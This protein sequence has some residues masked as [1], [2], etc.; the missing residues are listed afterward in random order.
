MVYKSSSA[1]SFLSIFCHSTHF[2][3]LESNDGPVTT[4]TETLA[5]PTAAEVHEFAGRAHENGALLTVFGRC[6]VEYVGAAESHLSTGDRHVMV[7][8]DGTVLVHTDE[9]QRPVNWQA[10]GGSLRFA[11]DEGFRVVGERGDTRLV[12]DFEMVQRASSFA[13]TDRG[14]FSVR[15]TEAD[16]KAR[17]LDEPELVE[18][19]FRPLSTERPTAAGPVD[20][21]GQDAD[22]TPVVVELK[23]RRAGPDAVG[24]LTR[25]VEAL[26]RDLHADA[27]IRGILVAPSVTNRARQLLAERGLEFV[28]LSAT[29]DDQSSS[30]SRSR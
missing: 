7:K 24:Q 11:A 20:V 26:D 14:E 19:G 8:P 2:Y 6:S 30:R 9:G 29:P 28:P 4:G 22:E 12:I 10:P 16:L 13:V 25:Y 3:P 18:R 1:H 21:Y 27:E 23:R 15:G 17:V 5:R